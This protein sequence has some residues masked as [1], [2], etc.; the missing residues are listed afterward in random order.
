[1][2]HVTDLA[3]VQAAAGKRHLQQVLGGVVNKLRRA[4]TQTM[5]QG[6]HASQ[7]VP[8]KAPLVGIRE[9]RRAGMEGRQDRQDGPSQ[10]DS[11]TTTDRLGMRAQARNR[12]RGRILR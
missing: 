8:G 3:A 7:P 2:R 4:E 12:F 11:L 6:C 1:M 5:P 10:S 9:L